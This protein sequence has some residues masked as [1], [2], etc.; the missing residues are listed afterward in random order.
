MTDIKTAVLCD[1]VTG[2]FIPTDR[3]KTARL[4]VCFYL[5]MSAETAAENA[6]LP[7]ML[8]GCGK[9]YPTSR[10]LSCRLDDLYGAV[11]GAECDKMGDM[12]VLRLSISCVENKFV[13]DGADLAAECARL[14]HSLIFE[15]LTDGDGFDAANFDKE[16]RLQLERID[17]EINNKRSY[18]VQRCEQELCRGEAGGLPRYG[19]R[20][21]LTQTTRESL[22]AAWRRVMETAQVRV[23]YL[24]S[25]PND[26]IFDVFA[27]GFAAFSRR[28]IQPADPV[29]SPAKA[30]V[31]EISDRLPVKQG[32]LVLGFR[33]SE[34]AANGNYEL[35]VLS[36]L[37]GGGAYSLLF[38]NV[39]E[40]LSLC[41]YCASRSNRRKGWLMV[42]SGV[43][44]DNMQKTFDEVLRQLDVLKN[45]EF[46]DADLAASKLSL[47]DSLRSIGDSQS[48][49]DRWYADRFFEPDVPTPDEVAERV[50][51]VSRDDI[52]RMAKGL[53]LDTVYRLLGSEEA[54]K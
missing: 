32:K 46:S 40:K 10:T 28:P 18:A 47:C 14:L 2:C 26:A 34:T 16:K 5:P 37:F 27:D 36:D 21:K 11:L 54:G 39:R 52:C 19:S 9:R 50:R 42:D 25:E 41:Y 45:G 48:V 22:Y 20:E 4:S 1:G 51:A 31:S 12:Q 49:T 38:A 35:M 15:P 33:Q 3:F 29:N 23:A 8:S 44:F 53:T 30:T 6:L 7:F 24:A 13:P 43:E 17:S